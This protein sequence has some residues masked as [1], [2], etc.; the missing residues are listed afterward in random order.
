MVPE[1]FLRDIHGNGAAE[2]L[3]RLTPAQLAAA[4][5]GLV[6]ARAFREAYTSGEMSVLRTGK[7]V[8][9]SFLSRKM[10]PYFQE[11]MFIDVFKGIDEWIERAAAGRFTEVDL[12]NYEKWARSVAPGGSRRPGA[13]ATLNLIE[14]G[15]HFL[16]KMSKQNVEGVTHLQRLHEML[17][18]PNMTGQQIRREFLTFG[19]DSGVGNKAIS[20]TLL[21]AGHTDVMVLDRVQIRAM[22]GSGVNVNHYAA[23]L[24]DAR[25]L[26]IYEAIERE[27]AERI[28]KIYAAAGRPDGAS[29]GRYHW[30]TWQAH[31]G[32]EASHETVAA[33]LPRGN[34]SAKALSEVRGRQ[35][36]FSTYSHGATYG[37]DDAGVPYYTYPKLSGG[38]HAFSV[39][40]FREFL[41]E[42][43][44]PSSRVV[45]PGFKITKD[46]DLNVPWIERQGQGIDRQK[47]DE[48]ASR[49][50][51]LQGDVGGRISKN[52]AHDPMAGRFDGRFPAGGRGGGSSGTAIADTKEVSQAGLPQKPTTSISDP[53]KAADQAALLHPEQASPSG[54]P[55]KPGGSDGK[56]RSVAAAGLASTGLAAA[57]VDGGDN[58]DDNATVPRAARASQNQLKRLMQSPSAAVREAA[59]RLFDDPRSLKKRFE[60]VGFD[61]SAETLMKDW[62]G[63]LTRALRG[64]RDAFAEHWKAAGALDQRE[65][66]EAVGHALRN[67]DE[68]DDPQVVRAAKLWR[69]QVLGPITD[70]AVKAGLLPD[71]VD[72]ATAGSYFSR[73]WSRGKLFAMEREFKETVA[74]YAAERMAREQ[75]T[76]G[77]ADARTSAREIADDL[78]DMLTGRNEAN[79]HRRFHIPDALAAS[80]LEDNVELIGRRL[81]RRIGADLELARKFGTPDMVG[82]LEQVRA[83]YA[84]LRAQA[85]DDNERQALARAERHDIADLESTRD[86]IR[87]ARIDSPIERNYAR[88]VR[89]AERLD[90]ARAAGEVGLPSLSDA[91][92]PA[93]VQGLSTYMQTVDRLAADL[94][95]VPISPGEA[96]L[97][98]QV[99]DRVLAHRLSSL[100]EI[101]DPY[102]SQTPAD[103]FLRKMT[104]TGAHENGVRI[105]A[106]MQKSFAAVMVQDRILKAVQERAG[107]D[108]IGEHAAARIAAQLE[109]HGEEIEGIRV[110][111]TQAWD[112]DDATAAALRAFRAAVNK[113]IFGFIAQD[114]PTG[115]AMLALKNFALASYQRLLL[116]G[117]DPKAERFVGGLIAMTAMGMFVA[118]TASPDVA[119]DAERWIGEGFERSG[120]M[121]VQLELSDAFEKATGFDP[122]GPVK[123]PQTGTRLLPFNAYPGIRAMVG[124]ALRAHN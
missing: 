92:R 100:T 97:A 50:A 21:M 10:Q 32:Q 105:F 107:V 113:D 68:A 40:A 31:S 116:R 28:N 56:V 76:G 13:S 69:A 93:M 12:S 1:R 7:L 54:D 96:E 23:L 95:A 3:K 72:P 77:R 81:V 33:I 37:V 82:T 112:R 110:A 29:I 115:A 39:P 38:V 47:L 59:S 101:D 22:F 2:T 111:N 52:L 20:L 63:G 36:E 15:Q 11:S 43:R 85:M 103:A 108:G 83:G 18:D 17:S 49:L 121:A 79:P 89:T 42:I 27:L 124:Y 118:W 99:A 74:Q 24:A 70:A 55:P 26:L 46:G 91:V 64:T 25:G 51:D 119:S 34:A 106:D 90:A 80:F 123:S 19:G 35:G 75:S 94:D 84:G 9:W 86:L 78:F 53:N 60:E 5:Q 66:N 57:S 88:I 62:N 65:F 104:D 117:L 71:D 8:L 16:I 41:D 58:A 114:T 67:N 61:V 4:D 45:K 48:T 109:K 102:A 87:G 14:F 44:K 122:L 120:I 98:R 30:E 73:T 6:R